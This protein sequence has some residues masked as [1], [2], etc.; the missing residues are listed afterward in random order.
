MYLFL[1]LFISFFV[2]VSREGIKKI[3][4]DCF[5][6]QYRTEK[7]RI[8]MEGRSSSFK[9]HLVQLPDHLRANQKLEGL[10]VGFVQIPCKHC[11][12]QGISCFFRRPC[13]VSDHPHGKDNFPNVQ[14]DPS[15]A[16]VCHS[17]P[18]CQLLG[19]EPGTSLCFPSS[20]RCREQ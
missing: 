3:Q 4:K 15:L 10:T 16:A 14:S 12:A 17:P 18:C 7:N 11:Q 2:V 5:L 6:E 9:D 13:P 1:Y 19:A 8:Q 20:G